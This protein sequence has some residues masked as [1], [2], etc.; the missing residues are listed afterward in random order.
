MTLQ[1][2]AHTNINYCTVY[3]CKANLLSNGS[4]ELKSKI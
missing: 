4:I 1:T 3:N 2:N